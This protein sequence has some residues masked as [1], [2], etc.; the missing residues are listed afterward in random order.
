MVPSIV[1]IL[2]STIGM[3]KN[4]IQL[5]F[6]VRP[7]FDAPWWVILNP[8]SAVFSPSSLDAAG[9]QIRNRVFYWSKLFALGV[10]L[11]VIGEVLVLTTGLDL[12]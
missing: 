8:M 6:H 1:L 12:T 3:L 11:A 7:Y 2:F 4:G 5:C 10:V 9:L